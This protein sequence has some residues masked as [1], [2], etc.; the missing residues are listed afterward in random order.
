MNNK[1]KFLRGTSGEYAV[2]EKDSDTIYFT[3][4]DG[5]LYIGDKEVSGSDITIDDTLSDTSTNP[6]QGNV[7]KQ[8]IDNKA[9]KT[10]ATT[11]DDGLMSAADK[12]KLDDADNTY[13]LKSKYGDTTIDVG[14]K[15]GTAGG[16]RSTAEGYNTTASG[17]YSHAEGA[18]TTASGNRSHAEGYLCTASSG[19][20]HA[21]GNNTTASGAHSHSEGDNTIA[22]GIGS[23]AGGTSSTASGDYSFAHGMH[24]E[25]NNSCEVSLGKFNKSSSD[26]L[27]SIG[28]GKGSN[29]KHNAFEITTTGGKLHDK[30]IAVDVSNPNLLINPDFKINQRGVSGTFSEAGKYFVDRWRLVFGAVTVNADGTL[31]LNGTISQ[32]FENAVGDNVTASV[33]AGTATYDNST[34]TFSITA[35]GEII[36][37]AKLEYGSNATQ[38]IPPDPTTELMKCMRY[39]EIITTGADRSFPAIL[40]PDLHVE[41]D[42][43]FKVPKRTAPSLI[44]NRIRSVATTS[45]NYIVSWEAFQIYQSEIYG[46]TINTVNQIMTELPSYLLGV[47]LDGSFAVDAEIY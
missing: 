37:W 42:I 18:S 32:I 9:D 13:A 6:V 1:V 2:A 8:A 45:T 30:D 28:D 40:T 27:F 31:T 36:S 4:D 12:V 3:T 24:V 39:Y 23:H 46:I 35:N 47:S 15:A 44:V 25:S 43:S 26:T 7:I 16:I 17:D 11:T 10:V 38:F 14:R 21:E 29:G 20:S 22:S 19:N 5:K 33:S 34:K 41:A